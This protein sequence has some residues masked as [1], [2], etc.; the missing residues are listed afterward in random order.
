MRRTFLDWKRA[1]SYSRFLFSW[2]S[3]NPIWT[4]KTGSLFLLTVESERFFVEDGMKFFAWEDVI[5]LSKYASM[6]EAEVTAEVSA[7]QSEI[8]TKWV[9]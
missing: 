8:L 4:L 3:L 9:D 7:Q 5:D 1:V 2:F 6:S